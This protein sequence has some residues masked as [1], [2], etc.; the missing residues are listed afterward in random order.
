MVPAPSKA[1]RQSWEEKST[2]KRRGGQEQS[3]QKTAG[4]T[5]CLR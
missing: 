3:P 1:P 4:S 5:G 2:C